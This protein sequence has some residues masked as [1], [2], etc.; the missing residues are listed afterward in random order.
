MKKWLLNLFLL[1]CENAQKK[2]NIN[3]YTYNSSIWKF[4]N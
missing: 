4:K 2:W 3:R 1:I